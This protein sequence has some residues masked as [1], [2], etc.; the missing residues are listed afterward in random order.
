MKVKVY[1]NETGEPSEVEGVDAR[2]YVRSGGWS[3]NPPGEKQEDKP[4]KDNDTLTITAEM[5]DKIEPLQ[6]EECEAFVKDLT[7]SDY[8]KVT[9]EDL[10]A[11]AAKKPLNV[12]F[13]GKPKKREIVAYL[14]SKVVE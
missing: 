4:E 1:N 5:L 6:P 3:M 11:I 10:K 2:E 13:D 9:V 7:G 8:A 14:K 12:V